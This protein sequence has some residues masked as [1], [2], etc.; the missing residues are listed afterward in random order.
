MSNNNLFNIEEHMN[1]TKPDGMSHNEKIRSWN[2]IEQHLS[3][4]A[5]TFS[6]VAFWTRFQS[7]I[8]AISVGV[9]ILLSG[10]AT[11]SAHNAKPGDIFFPIAVAGEKAQILFAGGQKAKESL[12]IKFAEKRLAEVKELTQEVRA[13]I[14]TSATTTVSGTTTT[15]VDR[16]EA[17]KV[18]RAT[19][20]IEVALLQLTET[21][22]AL[23]A[24]GA[25]DAVAI[26]DDI[27]AELRGVGNGNVDITRIASSG[28][29]KDGGNVTVRAT[30]TSTSSAASSFSGTVKIDEKKN[31]ARIV[32]N[33]SVNSNHTSIAISENG[34]SGSGK[35]DNG[36]KGRDS[37]R[38]NSGKDDDSEDEDEDDDRDNRRKITV[39]HKAGDSKHSITISRNAVRPHLAHGDRLGRCSGEVVPPTPDTVAPTISGAAVSPAQTSAVV[40]W[41]TNEVSTASLWLGTSSPVVT[42][43]APTASRTSL[44]TSQSLALTGL[45]EST[46]YFVIVSSRDASGNAATSSQLSFTTLSPTLPSDTTAPIISA[47]ETS[48]VGTTGVTITWATSE[49]AKTR[50][51][52]STSTVVDT[53]G[54]PNFEEAGFAL[55]HSVGRSGLMPNTTYR[56]ILTAV[57]AAGNRSTSSTATFTTSALPPPADTTAPSISLVTVSTTTNSATVS[58]STNELTTALLY[59]GTANPVDYSGSKLTLGT[60]ATSH[61][62]LLSGLSASTSYRF[63]IVAK[64]AAGNTATSSQS[65][66]TIN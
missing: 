5:K 50:L 10:A 31:G 15:R 65:E 30:F 7:R 27:I 38:G 33:S 24:R 29:K 43:G 58:W 20:G 57:D 63:V 45:R 25:T 28:G 2:A 49:G 16:K 9:L 26:L 66:F 1:N 3:I 48:G 23:L 55:S 4:R 35:N 37:H 14:A 59:F 22:S 54:A 34:K 64:D 62:A 8:V 46:T 13:T 19:R 41:T 40:T 47:I 6:Y 39:C 17:E 61:S 51:F 56:F 44:L 36:G 18:A 11:A 32:L 53:S 42:T 52:L 12:H 60:Q 21:R